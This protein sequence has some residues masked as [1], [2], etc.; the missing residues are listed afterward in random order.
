MVALLPFEPIRSAEFEIG[1]TENIVISELSLGC[2]PNILL[3]FET[4]AFRLVV[5]TV[6]IP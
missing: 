4:R 2:V 5:V 1:C 6:H 3:G